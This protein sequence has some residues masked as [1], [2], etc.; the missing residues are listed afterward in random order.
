MRDA[1]VTPTGFWRGAVSE[2]EETVVFIPGQ[3]NWDG[4]TNEEQEANKEKSTIF[5]YNLAGEKLCEYA[6]GYQCWGGDMS[7]DGSKVFYQLVP[8]GGTYSIGMLDGNDG[9]LLWKHETTN[10]FPDGRPFEGLE[11]RLSNDGN[12][13]AIGVV[14]GFVSLFNANTGAL[15]R[16]FP[17]GPTGDDT[18]GQVRGIMFDAADE[19]VYVGSG[20][21]FLRKVRVSDGEVIWKAF[22][23]GWPFVNG[24]SMSSDES[25]IITGTKSFDQARINNETGETEWIKDYG[26]LEAALSLNDSLV[27][28]FGGLMMDAKTGEYVTSIRQGAEGHFFAGDTLVARVDR[29]VAPYYTNGKAL[30]GS[31]PSGGGLGGGEQSQWSYMKPDGSLVIIACRDM[32]TD[33]GNQVGIAFYTGEVERR[34]LDPNDHPTDLSLSANAIDENNNVDAEV[35]ILS[36]T[37]ADTGDT[38]LYELIEGEGDDDNES[39]SIDGDKLIVSGVL[40]FEEKSSYS[41]RIRTSDS[42]QARY[43]KT[44]T[45]TL[46]NVNDN[47]TSINIDN[48]EVSENLEAETI[49]GTLSSTDDDSNDSHSYSLVNGSGDDDNASFTIDNTSIK[50]AESFNFES[51]DAYSIL[52]RTDDGNGGAFDQTLTITVTDANDAPTDISISSSS[53]EEGLD[54]GTSVGTFTSTDEDSGDTFS[55][56]LVS[57][58]GD[59]DNTA[60]S[61]SN[62]ELLSAAVF[63]T[64]DAYSIRIKTEDGEGASFEKEFSITIDMVTAIE[65]NPSLIR[66]FIL[67]LAGI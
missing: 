20:D 45:I 21:N 48:T 35:G 9:S 8:N 30:A 24:L 13:A 37:D 17:N 47:P 16:Q 22:I 46:N 29:N 51:K 3:E 63:D 38:F 57:G 64:K 23:G 39:F 1:I 56:S 33:P 41:I 32:V 12:I 44:F 66:S 19:H 7:R 27:I 59:T 40:D 26:Y 34:A 54:A 43:T 31:E 61:I 50:T 65:S 36:T 53:I 4:S 14:S 25:F 11:A 62:G 42:N 60:F 15:I 49:V 2:S 28:N 52:V 5:K 6:T 10:L 18:W 67:T 55:Y 58:T